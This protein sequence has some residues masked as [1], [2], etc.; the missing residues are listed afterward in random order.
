MSASIIEIQSHIFQN[1]QSLAD[2]LSQIRDGKTV[3]FT[4][5]CFDILHTGHLTYLSKARSLGDILIIAIN[6][7]ESVRK[8]KGPGRPV[9][10]ERDRALALACLRFVDY[11][12]FF[13]EQTPERTIEILKPEIHTK[14]GDY[15]PEDLPEKRVIDSYGGKIELIQFVDGYSTTNLIEKVQK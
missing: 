13:S 8:L 14:G 11:V 6:N 4:N 15:R 10:Q 9:N 12:T 2:H 5:G 3:V 7:D 1:A